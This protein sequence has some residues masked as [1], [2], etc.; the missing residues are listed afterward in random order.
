MRTST[1][2]QTAVFLTLLGLAVALGVATTWATVS[3]FP[4]GEYR[5]VVLVLTA[6]IFCFL[7]AMAYYRLFLWIAPLKE[8]PIQRNSRDEFIYHVYELFYLVIFYS[9]TRSHLVPVP[10]MRLI[11]IGLGARLGKNSYSAGT[12]FDPPFIVVGDNCIIGHDALLFC[13][14]VEGDNLE[15][16]RILI[17][18]NVTIGGRAVV[19]PGVVI[20]NGAIVAINAVVM[21]GSRIGAGEVWSGNPARRKGAIK[22]RDNEVDGGAVAT[23]Q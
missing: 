18:N 19:M 8:G 5:G 12:L 10:L 21:K 14:V 1:L 15:L 9:F 7:Y 17:G 6:I 2:A 4:L 11:Y 16:R 13:H 20:E 23:D 22:Q 3:R